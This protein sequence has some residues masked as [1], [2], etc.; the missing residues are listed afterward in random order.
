MGPIDQ[1]LANISVSKDGWGLNI[2]PVLTGEGVNSAQQQ[3]HI[4]TDVNNINT[5]IEDECEEMSTDSTIL[6]TG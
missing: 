6:Q 2:I 1:G 4:N 5:N 3:Q